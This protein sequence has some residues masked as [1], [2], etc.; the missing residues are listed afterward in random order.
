M[1]LVNKGDYL[2]VA[3]G[4]I[5]KDL[6]I[7][8]SYIR[9]PYVVMVGEDFSTITYASVDESIHSYGA[10]PSFVRID[11]ERYGMMYYGDAEHGGTN[12]YYSEANLNYHMNTSYY[13]L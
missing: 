11:K 10:Y 4:H 2:L 12:L 13:P 1:N 5:F 3:G 6:N 8:E 7:S 9:Q